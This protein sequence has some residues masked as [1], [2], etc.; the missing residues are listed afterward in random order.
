VAPNL[1][2]TNEAGETYDDPS[3]DLLFELLNELGEGNS[4]LIVERLDPERRDHFMQT[5]MGPD[6]TFVLEYREGPPET[7]FS[8]TIDSMRAVHEVMTKWGFDLPGWR[9]HLI[10]TR[11]QY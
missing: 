7:H 6:R 5:V 10:W 4:F 11:V 2:A 1:R 9:D 3:E 8:T